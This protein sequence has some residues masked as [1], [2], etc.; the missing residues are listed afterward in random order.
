MGE[1]DWGN[2]VRDVDCTV[3]LLDLEEVFMNQCIMPWKVVKPA[4]RERGCRPS[5]WPDP[6][7]ENPRLLARHSDQII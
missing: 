1:T 5:S 2:G 3:P 4:R 7:H 6:S